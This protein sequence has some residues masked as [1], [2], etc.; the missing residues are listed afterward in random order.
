[1]YTSELKGDNMSIIKEKSMMSDLSL[2]L[3]PGQQSALVY[4]QRCLE[5]RHLTPYDIVPHYQRQ[6]DEIA[7]EP[8]REHEAFFQRHQGH[9]LAKLKKKTDRYWAD[10]PLWDPFRTAY[11]EVT[12]GQETFLLKSWRTDI[13]APRQYALLRG[14]LTLS[15]DVF[16]P[17]EPLR[18]TLRRDLSCPPEQS[19]RLTRLFQH[20]VATLPAEELVPAYCSSDDPQVSFAH[21]AD[22][23]LR[24]LVRRCSETGVAIERERLWAFLVRNQTEEELT[25]EMRQ[26]CNL[27]F[28]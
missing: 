8:E 27:Q 24:I 25:V 23:H 7:E 16:L 12:D 28:V 3:P 6:E 9:P 26:R 15:T 22:H 2:P 21:L 17:E 13:T 11:Q 19:A 1:M 14:S 20:T 5:V 10:R 18:S 4:C